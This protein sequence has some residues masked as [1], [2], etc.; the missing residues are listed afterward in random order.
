MRRGRPVVVDGDAASATAQDL[1]TIREPTGGDRV[2]VA[3]AAAEFVDQQ[4]GISSRLVLGGIMLAVLTYA[5]LWL[6]TGS[7][8]LLLM[9]LLLNVLTVG[10]ALGV[11]T[12]VFGEGRLTGLL[13]YTSNGGIEG[14]GFPV[15]AVLIFAVS[16]HYGIFLRGRIREA[17]HAGLPVREAVGHGLPRTGTVIVAALLQLASRTTRMGST[18]CFLHAAGLPASAA[19]VAAACAAQAA[20]TPFP[21]RGELRGGHRRAARRGA[22]RRRRSLRLRGDRGDGHGAAGRADGRRLLLS[23]ALSCRLLGTRAPLAVLRAPPVAVPAAAP[24]A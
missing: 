3:G 18:W 8:I 1:V 10:T 14:T 11:I 6:M 17:H 13:D 12:F 9:A 24:A 16:T 15:A 7:V 20:A 2:L 4:A 5:I 22:R 21:C 23:V 19:V